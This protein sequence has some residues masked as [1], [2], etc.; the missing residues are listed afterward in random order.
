MLRYAII[1]SARDLIEE[2]ADRLVSAGN[3][4]SGNLVVFPGKRPA[5][6]LRKCIAVRR[7]TAFVPPV[8]LS[9]EE[10]IDR[11]YEQTHRNGPRR[12]ETIDAVAFLF[13]MH[14]DMERPLGGREF[15]NLET[16]FPLGLRIYRDIEELLI[17]QVDIRQLRAVESLIDT[18]LPPQAGASLQ[19]LS[20]F[21]DRFYR[22]IEGEGFS[23]R[24]ERFRYV[25][26]E[27]TDDGLPFE[28]IIFSGFY[29]LTE[30]ER[31][32]FRKLLSWERAFFLFQ[33]GPGIEEKLSRL[34]IV[35]GSEVQ[36]AR[37][38]SGE[39]PSIY[40]HKS[41]D[42][43]GQVFGLS[44]VLKAQVEEEAE[45]QN[46]SLSPGGSLAVGRTVIVLPSSETLF[47]LLYHALPLIPKEDYNI[48][49]GY[50]LERTP[51]WGFLSS[52]I[53]VV[54]SMDDDRL[55]IPDY[56]SLVLHP[57]T[58]NIYM[59]GNA[60]ITRIIFHALEESLLEDR[61][62]SFI[63]L[64]E[65]EARTKLFQLVSTRASRS[66]GAVSPV[67]IRQHLKTIHDALI[68]KACT[69][70]D[71][72]DFAGK[73]MEILS[74]IYDHSS[75]RLHP[76]FHPFAESFMKEL[77][78]LGRSRTR[79][80]AFAERNSY[81]HFLRRYV[82]Q[83][84]TP[85]EGTP[86]RGVQVLGFLETRN[87]RF[88]RTYILDANEDVIPDT[89][90][91]DSL[92]PF[93]VRQILGVPTYVDR[94]MLSAYYFYTLVNGSREVHIF[95]AENGRKEKSRFVEQLLWERQKKDKAE[96]VAGYIR[97]LGYRLSLESSL[98]P[99]ILK[100]P[101]MT[102]FLRSRTYDAT[103]LDV[104]LNCPLQ[105]YYRYVLN[106]AKREE[107]RP[108][109]ERLDIGRIVH[110]ILFTYFGRRMHT[111]LTEKQIDRSEMREV[112][113][114]SFEEA[115][116]PDPIGQV[117]LLK[118]QILRQ[119]D[120]F[121]KLYQAPLI[122]RAECVI[123]HLEHRLETVVDPFRYKGVMDR[124]ETR[125]GTTC[126][127]DYKTGA[128]VGRLSTTFSKLDVGD[129]KSWNE[130]IGSLQLPFYLFLYEQTT[131]KNVG[132]LQAMFVLLGKV[133]LDEGAE[134]PLFGKN[135]DV[136]EC[137]AKAK[138]VIR[139]LVREI[140][141]PEMPFDP[142]GRAKNAC[143]FCDFQHLCAAE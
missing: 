73:M 127:V 137:Y 2:V 132:D 134:L 40:F 63:R 96:G 76:Y 18:P 88:E 14:R 102:D 70:V 1:P 17:E 5:H 44:G 3:D 138:E 8:I 15:L 136:P 45:G 113:Q 6:F 33:H 78:V 31:R 55:Y 13:E 117:Y 22:T 97:S 35:D 57:Y 77:D 112:V 65:I 28:R 62:K 107:V 109:V 104:Y 11:V 140:A 93:K 49:L 114:L 34:G 24:S 120:A 115:Y 92:L 46:G 74:F 54:T 9:I 122:K 103:S 10:F 50:P 7:G 106:L 87:L 105:F 86:L 108:D 19:S 126:I 80:L 51:T 60:E 12:M 71:I 128:S 94:D 39:G 135:D 100:T 85:F 66:E 4:Y 131:G 52:L 75:A 119:M 121:L 95:F 58:K 43:H 84:F 79:D 142:R 21:F 27:I 25:S 32:L 89:R 141:D 98:P 42:S 30:C 125:D 41:P 61:T 133:R 111:R 48:S 20:F 36:G 56:L 129:R 130:A 26:S 37:A 59:R 69:F 29:A 99:A 101:S 91:E 82:A 90:K 47:P 67:E 72:K 16:F 83:C 124:I 118:R 143:R 68:R 123:L 38:S 81:F 110:R 23:S 53:Q 64:D 116:G 139:A